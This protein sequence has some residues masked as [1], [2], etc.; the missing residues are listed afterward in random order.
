MRCQI[1][2]IGL[3]AF[4]ASASAEPRF[5]AGASLGA[6]RFDGTAST[7]VHFPYFGP[8]VPIDRQTFHSTE[9][10]WGASFGW[11]AK[12]WLAVELGYSDLGNSGNALPPVGIPTLPPPG[13]ERPPPGVSYGTAA[14][15]RND[16]ALEIKDWHVGARFSVALSSRFQANWLAAVSRASF[17]AGGAAPFLGGGPPTYV[18]FNSPDDETGLVW[19]FGFGWRVNQWLNLE[20]GFRRHDTR[21]LNVDTASIGVLFAF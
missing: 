4:G 13:S 17:E 8:G 18:R 10:T 9:T 16:V 1:L 11:Q 2:T 3:L 6:S 7:G 14:S 20:L 21:V 12:R 15:I 5:Y 19:G